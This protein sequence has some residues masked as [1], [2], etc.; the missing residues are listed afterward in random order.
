MERR[1]ELDSRSTLASVLNSEVDGR[2]RLAKCGDRSA[3]S[4]A[5]ENCRSYL[6]LVAAAEM[7][8]WLR[9]KVGASDIVQQTFLE[10]Y[11]GFERFQGNNTRQFLGWL[12]RMMRNHLV[13]VKRSYS[14]QKRET[15]REVSLDALIQRRTGRV[16][17]FRDDTSP[18]ERCQREALQHA[19][20]HVLETLNHDERRVLVLR[21]EESLRFREIGERMNRS[22]DAARMLWCRAIAKLERRLEPYRDELF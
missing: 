18:S 14:S 1:F 9:C 17:R 6:L 2:I 22:P 7:E 5:M 12:I 4:A 15:S 13:D 3:L 11:E 10:A 19:V 16:N 20:T 21:H 8:D